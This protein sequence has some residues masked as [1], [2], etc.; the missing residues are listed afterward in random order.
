MSSFVCI[1]TKYY[2]KN[3][4]AK[5]LKHCKRIVD[6]TYNAFAT[7]SVLGE[8]TKNNFSFEFRKL[9]DCRKEYKEINKKRPR[10]DFN[11]CF[12]HL[13]IF[14]RDQFERIERLAEKKGKSKEYIEELFKKYIDE[15]CK[16]IKEKYGFEPLG[17]H[18]HMDEGHH[19]ENGNLKRN[20]H[21]HVHFYNYD[22][23][24]KLAPL[25]K[26]QKKVLDPETGKK[27]VNPAFSDFQTI[28][29]KTF[30]K[31][32]FKRGI[33]KQSTEKEHLDRDAYIAQ[34]QKEI[35]KNQILIAKKQEEQREKQKRIEQ[36]QERKQEEQKQKE[37]DIL[38]INEKIEKENKKLNDLKY[39][40]HLLNQKHKLLK[41]EYNNLQNIL[42]QLH[43]KINNF[44]SNMKDW[45]SKTFKSRIEAEIDYSNNVKKSK[46]ELEDLKREEAYKEYQEK[47]N[48]VIN[49]TKEP[50]EQKLRI[51]D[52]KK[53]P[54]K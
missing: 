5:L 21:A 15:Y 34:K 45:L 6:K 50:K 25:K 35:E 38:K 4:F 3:A 11:E 7:K 1:R 53:S 8:Y 13:L 18:F 40:N 28:A 37:Q 43:T 24:N 23:K 52:K 51:L 33:S 16:D 44:L 54:K 17:F 27:E 42:N 10:K 26:I 39:D 30:K 48:E 36:E 20:I 29:A 12:E 46:Q 22:F 9:S 32:G 49:L 47:I 2:K 19:D 31:L 14:S 41:D